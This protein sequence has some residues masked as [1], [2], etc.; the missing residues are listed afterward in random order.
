[1]KYEAMV[2]DL[3][4]RGLIDEHRRLTDAGN[5]YCEVLMAANAAQARSVNTAQRDLLCSRGYEQYPDH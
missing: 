3:Q 4:R 5:A 1:M 2:R